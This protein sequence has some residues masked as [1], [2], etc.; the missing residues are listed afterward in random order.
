MPE[1]ASNSMSGFPAWPK[2]RILKRD[3]TRLDMILLGSYFSLFAI[4][5]L[6][7]SQKHHILPVY[8]RLKY[9]L[10]RKM[11]FLVRDFHRKRQQAAAFVE[12]R[13]RDQPWL[14]KC[15]TH[16]LNFF[17]CSRSRLRHYRQKSNGSE[18]GMIGGMDGT[19]AIEMNDLS[20]PERATA[21]RPVRGI[22]RSSASTFVFPE[23][24]PVEASVF[25]VIPEADSESPRPSINTS[26]NE[27]ITHLNTSVNTGEN[28]DR[29][30]EKIDRFNEEV[31]S[32][33]NEILAEISES[34]GGGD[35]KLDKGKGKAK[36]YL[37]E[38]GESSGNKKRTRFEETAVV[39]KAPSLE[40][41]E[42]VQLNGRDAADRERISRT[43]D[44]EST[45]EHCH[46][47]VDQEATSR[48]STNEPSQMNGGDA[49]DQAE[50]N[51]SITDE[52]TDRTDEVVVRRTACPP[53]DTHETSEKH[54][55]DEPPFYLWTR[56][57][58]CPSPSPTSSSP[59]SSEEVVADAD[60]DHNSF[61]Y[62]V[63]KVSSLSYDSDDALHE[64]E[65][66]HLL[67]WD[68]DKELEGYFHEGGIGIRTFCLRK[69]EGNAGIFGEC[70]IEKAEGRGFGVEAEKGKP[71]W[72]R[73]FL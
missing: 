6:C 21:H 7:I 35:R 64:E 23:D 25:G 11:R 29:K 47:A 9:L 70:D 28:R 36:E 40:T 60:P 59:R 43:G 61:A 57:G 41:E 55:E 53:P 24:L 17:R 13:C 58:G 54:D 32:E 68:L 30:M 37:S 42:S 52:S 38:T 48:S 1:I 56:G 12:E 2:H 33:T 73:W 14:R 3:F 20:T 26:E 62:D 22:L 50:L 63:E 44:K 67:R 39:R 15:W 69:G 8:Y 16:V 10:Q 46:G 45:E 51:S 66:A 34:S 19:T 18:V 72:E 49:A 65:K 71:W 31:D 4:C 27:Y 5:G